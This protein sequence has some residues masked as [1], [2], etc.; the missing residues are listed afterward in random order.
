M[1]QSRLLVV[2]RSDRCI[3]GLR[4]VELD[5]VDAAAVDPV[6]AVG[7]V[8][9]AVDAVTVDRLV[10]LVGLVL[11][12]A[13][14]SFGRVVRRIVWRPGFERRGSIGRIPVSGGLRIDGRWRTGRTRAR[15]LAAAAVDAEC[16]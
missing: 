12:V 1:P 8:V 2:R 11:R 10:G 6:H 16:R 14:E 4:D 13:V 7:G 15:A 3:V 5:F 9:V